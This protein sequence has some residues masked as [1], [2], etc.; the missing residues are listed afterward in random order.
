MAGEAIAG[1][2]PA[3]PQELAKLK[4]AELKQLCRDRGLKVGG[5]KAELVERLTESA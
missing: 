1:A 4:V 3:P 2:P 5:V